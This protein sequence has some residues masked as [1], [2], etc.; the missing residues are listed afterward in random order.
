MG[1]SYKTLNALMRHIRESTG[2]SIEGGADKL[3]LAQMGYFHGYKGYRYSGTTAKRI[4]YG[5]FRELRAVMEFDSGLKA[6]FYPVL[7]R[8]EMMME[9]L[10]LVEML[11]AAQSSSL[12][13]VYATLMPGTK[14]ENKQG[15]LKVIHANNETLLRSYT[16]KNPIIC[17]YYD[18]PQEAVPLW[19][20]IEVIT[21]GHFARFL[22]QLDD[23]TLNA[24]ASRWGMRRSDGELVPHL[25]YAIT[26]LRNCVAHNGVVFD[27]RFATAKVR[28]EV[29][30]L[31]ATRIGFPPS[32]ALDFK[33][34]TDYFVLVVYLACCLGFPK[35]EVKALIKQFRELS[36]SLR[37][38]VPMSVFDT[39]VHTGSRPKLLHL[40]QWIQ[41]R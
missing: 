36:E 29:P 19:A 24:I 37:E 4:P 15:K 39:I 17:H 34:I 40:E 10:A 18:S 25:I 2:I 8:L 26:S 5:E 12:V 13:D 7:M 32:T 35:R 3:A 31:L 14:R 6:L 11:D 21:L 38:K 22:E 33:S 20:L 1:Q 23:K 30:A 9:N 16:S 28:K 27:T 41:S